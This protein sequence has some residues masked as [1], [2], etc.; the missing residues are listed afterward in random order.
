MRIPTPD[1]C[2]GCGFRSKGLLLCPNCGILTVEPPEAK[3]SRRRERPRAKDTT[4]G[5]IPAVKV[6]RN[7]ART[8]E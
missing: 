3:T 5:R 4:G 2:P 7:R 6:R 8:P 1:V